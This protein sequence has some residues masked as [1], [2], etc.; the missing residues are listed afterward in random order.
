M[1]EALRTNV[2]FRAETVS[3]ALRTPLDWGEPY[4]GT[5]VTASKFDLGRIVRMNNGSANTYMI[6]PDSQ[7]LFEDGEAILL[8][9]YGAGT[10]TIVAGTGVTLRSLGGTL[11]ISGQ[12]GKAGIIKMDANEWWVAGDLA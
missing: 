11:A 2:P 8:M 6:P 10:T 4:T 1:T 12:Y 7:V 5:A 9:Q 3:E